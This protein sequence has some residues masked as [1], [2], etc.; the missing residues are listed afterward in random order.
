M[1]R[2]KGWF[3]TFEGG[4]GAGKSTMI[5]RTHKW[6]LEHGHQVVKT[7]EPGGTALAE[8]IR[9][10]VLDEKHNEL[11]GSAE[12]L[13]VFA[14]RAQHLDE[15]IRPSLEQGSTVLCDRFTDAT[16]AYQG[17]GRGLSADTIASLESAVHGDLQ[18]DLTLLLDLPVSVGMSRVSSR[19]EAD[20]IEQESTA[21]FE[22]VRQTYLSRAEQSA[23]RFAVID[24]SV[25]Q[26]AVWRQIEQV[27]DQR[28]GL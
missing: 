16:W 28:T 15:L 21:F 14:A 8:K 1:M 17:G 22:R 9:E 7:R 23:G 3:I 20:R 4:E 13:L 5:R 25:D 11:C 10:M 26:Q 6:L 24:A 27:L 12:L 18:P 2:A 19:G